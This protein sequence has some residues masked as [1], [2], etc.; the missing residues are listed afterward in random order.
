MLT[1]LVF[2]WRF[3]NFNWAGLINLCQNFRWKIVKQF[4]ILGAIGIA[5][6]SIILIGFNFHQHGHCLT[7]ATFSRSWHGV[8][9]YL[10]I[11]MIGFSAG[12]YSVT[13]YNELQVISP[14]E[15]LSQVI[16]VNNVLNSC[17]ML[18]C[19][20]ICILLLFFISLWWLFVVTI[21]SNLVFAL[22]YWRVNFEPSV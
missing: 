2:Y 7:L 16:G 1:C 13:C 4:V 19:S 6:F 18:F 20:L 21:I 11:F 17:Y 3:L 9:N 10:L 5:F 14:I 22:W 8:I 12:F 15:M